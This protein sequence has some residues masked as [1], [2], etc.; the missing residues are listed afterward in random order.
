MLQL[1]LLQQ[2]VMMLSPMLVLL[3][4]RR[5]TESAARTHLHLLCC[6]AEKPMLCGIPRSCGCRCCWWEWR[7]AQVQ[8]LLLLQTRRHVNGL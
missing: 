5:G 4:K 7:M 6:A 8:R 2:Q 3:W 1:L